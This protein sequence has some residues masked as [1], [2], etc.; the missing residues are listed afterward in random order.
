MVNKRVIKSIFLDDSEPRRWCYYYQKVELARQSSSWGEIIILWEKVVGD[1]LRPR[2][3]MELLPFIEA[4]AR[5]GDFETAMTLSKRASQISKGMKSPL[6]S[7]WRDV[8]G[9]EPVFDQV[10]NVFECAP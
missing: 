2:H 4:H 7:L 1:N 6:C 3:G 8:V 9:Q 5:M 10:K